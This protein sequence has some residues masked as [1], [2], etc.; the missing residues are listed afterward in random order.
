MQRTFI[1]LLMSLLLSQNVSAQNFLKAHVSTLENLR[2]RTNDSISTMHLSKNVELF[3]IDGITDI[4]IWLL[5]NDTVRAYLLVFF[6]PPDLQEVNN[7]FNKKFQWIKPNYWRFFNAEIS[8]HQY[9][10]KYMALFTDIDYI[11]EKGKFTDDERYQLLKMMADVYY[12]G[13]EHTYKHFKTR[14]MKAILRK[15]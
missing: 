8:M 3:T 9:D 13:E 10:N 4:N 11:F 5:I 2:Q 12:S 6:S 1:M 7:R 14:K 15:L